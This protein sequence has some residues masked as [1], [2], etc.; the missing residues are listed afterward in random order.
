[1]NEA[2]Q[3]FDALYSTVKIGGVFVAIALSGSV[4]IQGVTWT[5]YCKNIGNKC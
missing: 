2:K 4:R 5:N 1:M 3:L